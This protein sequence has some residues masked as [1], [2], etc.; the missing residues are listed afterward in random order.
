[1]IRRAQANT[2]PKPDSEM[3]VNAQNSSAALGRGRVGVEG[4]GADGEAPGLG[5]E[6]GSEAGPETELRD[7]IEVL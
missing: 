2:P 3:A 4:S 7:V 5:R 6:S 1:M